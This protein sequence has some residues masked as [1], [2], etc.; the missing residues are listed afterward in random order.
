MDALPEMDYYERHFVSFQTIPT[1]CEKNKLDNVV[2]YVNNI[3][4]AYYPQYKEYRVVEFFDFD[5]DLIN[6]IPAK[7]ITNKSLFMN[8]RDMD[9]SR[10][11]DEQIYVLR[12][13]K[14]YK[15]LS[16]I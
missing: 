15:M 5:I 7:V 11:C 10:Y 6:M 2:D 13:G 9:F 3:Y 16:N 1:P 8:L 12:N 4:I 14:I